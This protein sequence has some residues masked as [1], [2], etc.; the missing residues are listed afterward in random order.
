M[1]GYLLIGPINRKKTDHPNGWRIINQAGRCLALGVVVGRKKP[2]S[3]ERTA[4]ERP[5]GMAEG[6]ESASEALLYVAL[7]RRED[8]VS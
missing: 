3:G 6:S 7:P 2:E 1:P 4:Y 5:K 8:W